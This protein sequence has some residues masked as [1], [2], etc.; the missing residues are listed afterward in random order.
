MAHPDCCQGTDERAMNQVL[1]EDT[2]QT[3]H[4][5]FTILP[6]DHQFMFFFEATILW[7]YDG[8]LTS[9]ISKFCGARLSDKL[10]SFSRK[11]YGRIDV[12]SLSL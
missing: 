3:S 4:V 1:Q 10:I 11:V 12:V 7:G 9:N 6:T 2:G 5:A 8:D